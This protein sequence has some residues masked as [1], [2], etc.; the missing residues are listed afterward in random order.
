MQTPYKTFTPRA[1]RR[2]V[3]LRVIA[4]TTAFAAVIPAAGHAKA[5]SSTVKT[6]YIVTFKAGVQSSGEATKARGKGKKVKHVYSKALNGMAVELTAAEA[7]EMAK[8]QNVA[9]ISPDVEFHAS[10]DQFSPPWGLDRIDQRT[11]AGSGTYSFPANGGSGV[12]VYVVDTGVRSTHAELS[13]RVAA[14]ADFVGD[15]NGTNDCHGHGTHVAATVAGTT[16]GVAKYATIVPVRVLDCLGSGSSSGIIAGLDW[17]ATNNG[18]GAAVVNMSLGGTVQPDLDAA[19]QRVIDA[20]IPVAIAAGNSNVDACATSPAHVTA[21]VTVA[22]TDAADT[23]ASWSNWG[24]CVD[25]FA[26]G[27]AITSAWY[28]SDVATS[29]I[30]GTSMASPHVAGVLAL[31]RQAAPALTPAQLASNLKSAATANIVTTPGVGTPNLLAYSAPPAQSTTAPLA[32]VSTTLAAAVAAAP[33]S[34]QV[35]ATGGKAPYAFSVATG[36]LPAGLVLSTSTGVISGTPATAGTYPL[37][38]KVA[39]TAGSAVTATLTIVVQPAPTPLVF[40]VPT[41]PAATAGVTYSYTFPATGGTRPYRWFF[42]SGGVAP[43]L[44]LDPVAGTISGTPT[45]SGTFGFNIEVVD[46]NGQWVFQYSTLTV[47]PGAVPLSF[48]AAALPSGTVGTAY[49]YTPVATGGT[50]PYTWSFVGALPAGLTFSPL[51]GLTAGTPTTAG[52]SAFTLKVAD[53]KGASVSQPVTLTVVAGVAKPGAFAKTTPANGSTGQSTAV[54]L[55]WAASTG[56][57]SYQVCVDTVNNNACDGAWTST[58]ATRTYKS[59]LVA[60]TVYYWQVR[61]VNAGG[62]TDANTSVWWKLT[63]K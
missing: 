17:I 5:A 43:G 57:T 6:S 25:V 23:R 48:T 52:T 37:T 19:V 40:D 14:G 27:V 8:D 34:T 20:G 33:Y 53:A 46:A 59:A 42:V 49:A 16:Y 15:N 63:T 30:S 62:T 60:K 41:P 24:T 38:V 11:T 45:A 26:P 9:R 36:T 18:A 2:G 61:A 28:T 22:A 21:A 13:G 58:G 31:M 51:T 12:K 32:V 39:D 3:W 4:A 7:A 47:N 10:I 55:S 54:T 29:T 50:A 44:T 56:A 1:A 35:Y